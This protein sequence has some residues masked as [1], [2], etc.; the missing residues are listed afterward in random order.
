MKKIHETMPKLHKKSS[1]RT[2]SGKINGLEVHIKTTT[3]FPF[4]FLLKIVAGM[5]NEANEKM[6][7]ACI[8]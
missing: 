2:G 3:L 4:L 8:D 6:M 5:F 1:N 7:A